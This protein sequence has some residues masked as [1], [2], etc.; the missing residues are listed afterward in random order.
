MT[1]SRNTLLTLKERMAKA[2]GPDRGLDGL[3]ARDVLGWVPDF[4]LEGDR[5][6]LWPNTG[7]HWEWPDYE[8]DWLEQQTGDF[9]DPQEFTAS[10]DAAL[11]LLKRMLPSSIIKIEGPFWTVSVWTSDAG[12]HEVKN[13]DN[14]DLPLAIL[15]A[16][17]L[18]LI[19]EAPN[20]R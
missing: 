11:A 20:D 19:A 17:L 14:D 9:P 3:I 10:I 7:G 2:T 12:F 1:A 5:L 4:A 13:Y 16:L 6:L 18:V 8:D 15:S